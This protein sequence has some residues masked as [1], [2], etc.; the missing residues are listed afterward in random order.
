LSQKSTSSS[1]TSKVA[2]LYPLHNSLYHHSLLSVVV[3]LAAALP[4][5][6]HFNN[7]I[8]A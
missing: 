3:A 1:Q 5:R 6:H 4:N 7:A 8:P 2:F